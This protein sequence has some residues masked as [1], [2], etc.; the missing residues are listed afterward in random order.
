MALALSDD[1]LASIA[2]AATTVSHSS[3]MRKLVLG[4]I[5]ALRRCFAIF[6]GP[7]HVWVL[8]SEIFRTNSALPPFRWSASGIRW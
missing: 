1:Q 4:A 5:I 2:S 6:P 7:G 3:S 8:L